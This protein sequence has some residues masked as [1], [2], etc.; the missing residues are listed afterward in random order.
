VEPQDVPRKAE[1]CG[2]RY[3]AYI[4][5][6][7]RTAFIR[8]IRDACLPQ[9]IDLYAWQIDALSVIYQDRKSYINYLLQSATGDGK[10]IIAY[11]EIIA[12]RHSQPVTTNKVLYAVPYKKLAKEKKVDISHLLSVVL[13]HVLP[14][15]HVC[16]VHGTRPKRDIA[17]IR[18]AIA[19]YEHVLHYLTCANTQIK[20]YLR[21]G[22][23]WLAMVECYQL[24]VID[25]AHM[26]F[27][28]GRGFLV[29]QIVCLSRV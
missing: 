5:L 8:A 15:R 20:S 21:K 3:D 4:T 26:L 17:L 22:E 16:V 14:K 28:G 11:A 29:N 24:L 19:T 10:S 6:R 7:D 12:R 27:G 23:K 25:E 13:G 18:V 2:H 1:V 9:G